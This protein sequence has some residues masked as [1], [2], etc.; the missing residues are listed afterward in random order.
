MPAGALS[1]AMRTASASKC[2]PPGHGGAASGLASPAP[3]VRHR[4][5]PIASRPESRSRMVESLRA[6]TPCW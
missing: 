6:S 4:A 5:Q 1:G 2:S 3:R